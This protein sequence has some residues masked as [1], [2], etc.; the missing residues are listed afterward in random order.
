MRRLAW[1]WI[2]VVAVVGLVLPVSAADKPVRGYESLGVVAGKQGGRLTMILGDSPPSFFYYGVIDSNL[3]ALSQHLY[4]GLVEYNYRTYELEPALAEKWTISKDGRLYTFY[5]RRDVKWQDGRD[6]TADDVVFTFDQIVTNPEARAGDAGAFMVGGQRVRFEKVDTYTVRLTLPRAAPATLQYMRL[7]IMPKHKLL[8]HSVEGGAKPVDINSAWPTTVDPR[9]VIG[10]GP[11]RLQ[12]YVPGQKVTLV[13]NPRYWKTDAGGMRLPYLNQIELL[14]VRD[15]EQQVAQFLAGNVGQLNLSGA[16]FPDLK[17]RQQA[18]APF[19]VISS[20]TLFGS[21]PHLAFNFDARNPELAR[22][23]SDLRWRQAMQMAV[24]RQRI[25]DDVYNGL[26]ELPGHGVAPISSWY[27]DTR[28]FLGKFDLQGAA[29]ALDEL[30]LRTGPDGVRQLQ[31]GRPLEFTLTYGTDS[32]VWPPIA[33]I[34]QNDLKQIGVKVNLQG[35]LSRT[36]LSTGLSGNYEALLLAFGDQPDPE[37]RKPIWQPGGALYYWHRTTQPAT[38]GG[39]PNFAAMQPWER[40]VYDIWETGGTTVS[41]P[42]RKA[43][44]DK[45]QVL[46]AQNLPVIMIAKPMAVGAIQNRYGN[47]LYSLGVIPGYN[48]VPLIFQK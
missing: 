45:W 5:L 42:Q 8:P 32:A 23:F 35:I 27:F 11:F 9:E 10:T 44:Y 34:L 33:T 20:R 22:L 43:L 24:N 15:P 13:R 6:F 17:S 41:R 37:L 48:P 4:D 28:S 12:A 29:R 47:Y 40:Q 14:I 39:E 3:Q 25:I 26:A 16:Q 36:L 18:G 31:S 30:G 7:Y 46:F 38:P 1:L 19:K 21:P 2:F